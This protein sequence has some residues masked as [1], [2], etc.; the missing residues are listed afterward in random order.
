ML[1]QQHGQLAAM[2]QPEGEEAIHVTITI[3][4]ELAEHAELYML[5]GLCALCGKCRPYQAR[6]T[7]GTA[8]RRRRTR[9]SLDAAIAAGGP[10][11]TRAPLSSTPSFVPSA[12]ASPM[13]CVT[14]IT[15]FRSRF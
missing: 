15:V 7:A 1:R 8:S 12:K 6:G 2:R 10:H 9:G 13:S 5:R 14:T 11:A 3:T 4:S